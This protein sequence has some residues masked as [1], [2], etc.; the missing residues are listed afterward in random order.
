MNDHL[1]TDLADKLF[2]NQPSWAEVAEL[3]LPDLLVPEQAGGFGGTWQDAQSV[4]RLCGF[5]GLDLPLAETILAGA[6]LQR[7]VGAMAT[8]ADQCVGQVQAGTFSGEIASL[9]WG[10]QAELILAQ[11]QGKIILLH[12]REGD[13]F[14]ETI[15][16]GQQGA[17]LRFEGVACEEVAWNGDLFELGAIMRTAQMAGA[18]DGALT[19]SVGYA[20]DREQ[21]GKKLGKFQA[22]QQELAVFALEAAAAN[23]ASLAAFRAVAQ[24]DYGFEAAAAKLRCN[25]AAAQATRIAHQVHGAIGFTKEYDLQRFTRLIWGWRSSFGSEALWAERLGDQ[26]S[27]AGG[28]KLWQFMVERDAGAIETA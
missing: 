21:F 19:L 28:G 5:H 24:G 25:M 20:N 16:L 27:Q 1:L 11:C 13:R 8:L 9:A 7:P 15:L 26:A 14:D 12:A 2:S 6:V 22:V 3:G 23:S 4:M 18:F 17:S 10:H